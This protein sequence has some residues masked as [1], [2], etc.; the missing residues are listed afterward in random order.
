MLEM[1]Q[2]SES[3]QL[4]EVVARLERRT[5]NLSRVNEVSQML[6]SLLDEDE[7]MGYVVQASAEI[8]G[9]PVS[10]LWLWQDKQLQSL[11]CRAT[12][13]PETVTQ[14][15]QHQIYPDHGIG[16]WVAVN[17]QTAVT[18]D[19]YQDNRFAH[20]IDRQTGFFTQSMLAVPIV[21]RDMV[22]GVIEILNKES[23]DFDDEDVMMVETLAAA[24]AIA[25]DNARLVGDLQAKNE[26]LDA[27]SHTVAHDLKSPLTMVLGYSDM[28]AHEIEGIDSAEINKICQSVARSARK[29][30]S[31]IKELL[32]LSS[33]RKQ[34]V[35]FRPIDM[36]PVVGEA[37]QRIGHLTEQ[38][39]IELVIPMHWPAAYGY[40]PWIEE[41]WVNYISN[42]I[43]YGG[44]PA[45]VELGF[46]EDEQ[47]DI[48]FWVLD[49]GM[50]LTEAEQNKLFVPFTRLEQ[51]R[52]KGHGLGLSIVQRI[53]TK[54]GGTTAV[55]SKIG[56]G[57]CFKFSLPRTTNQ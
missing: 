21:L 18:R 17:G 24:A 51:V 33:V 40:A 44:Q 57:S 2:E 16:G 42:A 48:W 8:I 32:L 20:E 52:V 4:H 49:N 19:A 47:G 31:I 35:E 43:K 26:E 54:L 23:A 38:T 55:E 6:T 25:L 56:V 27:F 50:G 39:D 29:M 5:R 37:L 28:L 11:T 15:K 36:H 46:D 22:I 13:P 3:E 14:L 10:S 12:Y 1:S 41:I 53:V 45:R 34:A 9:A 30:D 7:V